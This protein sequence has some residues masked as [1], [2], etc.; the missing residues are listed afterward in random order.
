MA[1]HSSFSQK[2]LNCRGRACAKCGN[3]CDWYWSPLGNM[4]SYTKRS[5]A[6]C[7]A[8]YGYGL[9]D[10]GPGCGGCWRCCLG[11]LP[12][13]KLCYHRYYGGS[14]YG[15][16][17]GIPLSGF[18]HGGL[19]DNIFALSGV[20]LE[21]RRHRKDA[22]NFALT[23][24]VNL[25]GLAFGGGVGGSGVGDLFNGLAERADGSHPMSSKLRHFWRL[26]AKL[27]KIAN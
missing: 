26:I 25:A 24:A 3:C 18:L 4:K 27:K 19:N 22:A 23:G 17:G 12:C 20:D 14:G 15:H 2:V 16:G 11:H 21:A 5:D 6:T 1:A 10:Y 8:S 7:T 9:I 13:G